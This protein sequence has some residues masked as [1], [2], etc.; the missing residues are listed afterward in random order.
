MGRAGVQT[1]PALRCPDCAADLGVVRED[2]DGVLLLACPGCRARFRATRAAHE[3]RDGRP[4]PTAPQA[5]SDGDGNDTAGQ[6]TVGPVALRWRA[7]VLRILEHAYWTV[8]AT[9]A[10]AMLALGGFVPVL[11]GWLRNEVSGWAD[12]VRT[13]GGSWFSVATSDP[14]SDLGPVLGRVDAPLLFASIDAVSRRL[15]VRPPGQVRLTYL[16][17]CGVVAWKRSRALIVG[18]PLLRVLTQAELRAVLG[19]E[20]AHLARGDATRAAR[21]ARFVEGLRLALEQ[22]GDARGPL[23]AWARFCLREA[24]WLIEP[25]ARGQEDRADRSAALIAGGG[26][27]AS[28]LVKVALVQPLFREVLDCYDPDHPEYPNLYAFFRAFWFR[29]PPESLSA[30]RLQVLAQADHAH[31]P[32]HPP[33]P[34]R[35]AHLQSYPD[36]PCVNGD[37]QPATTLLGDLEI[38]EQMLHNRL[39]GGPAVEPT[40]FHRAGS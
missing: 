26:T 1:T 16:P 36:M 18:L 17:C 6:A 2:G 27:A 13:L 10:L 12:V 31:D 8:T 25:V 34:D 21:S 4:A 32:A 33:L 37:A 39:F 35:L 38:F 29:L 5:D 22:R 19:H 11:G 3:P 9:G 23:A 28:A 20:L 14:D 7:M 30:M 24:S 15:G 40:V